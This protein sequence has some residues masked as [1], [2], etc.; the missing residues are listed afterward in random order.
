MIDANLTGLDIFQALTRSNRV[1]EAAQRT[2]EA[3][4]EQ[5]ADAIL[6]AAPKDAGTLRASVRA[7]PG[8]DP[9]TVF[10]KAGGTPETTRTNKA[11]V[12]FDEALMLEWGTSRSA[13]QPFFYPTIERM[14]DKIKSN[15]GDTVE[16]ALKEEI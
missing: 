11:G 12:E 1:Q 3:E 8:S 13:A 9:L 5:L 10:V 6:D 16:N 14:R 15:I 2:V 7:E 4:A